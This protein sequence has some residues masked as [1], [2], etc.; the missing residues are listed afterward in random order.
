VTEEN[1]HAVLVRETEDTNRRWD[2]E[3]KALVES[4]QAYLRQMTHMYEEKLRIE[5]SIQR[6]AQK[7]KELLQVEFNIG[8]ENTMLI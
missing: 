3:N 5:Q 4:H 6:E 7:A 8:R 2:E 1:R